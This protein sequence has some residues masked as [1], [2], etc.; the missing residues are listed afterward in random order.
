MS[1]ISAGTM[2]GIAGIVR[3]MWIQRM[4]LGSKTDG[5][6]RTIAPVQLQ[7]CFSPSYD[8]REAAGQGGEKEWK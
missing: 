5:S 8:G 4:I 3:I 6:K 1:R 7:M 2:A